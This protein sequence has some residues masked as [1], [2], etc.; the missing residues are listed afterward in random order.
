MRRIARSKRSEGHETDRLG[1]SIPFGY[2]ATIVQP[3]HN[4]CQIL[5]DLKSTVGFRHIRLTNETKKQVEL[6][7]RML[8]ITCRLLMLQY[9]KSGDRWSQFYCSG[10]KTLSLIWVIKTKLRKLWKQ[11]LLNPFFTI[12]LFHGDIVQ[13]Y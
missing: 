10:S 2:I 5:R 7:G 6:L 4:S 12:P 1:R 11:F 8:C 9:E 13:F 3:T